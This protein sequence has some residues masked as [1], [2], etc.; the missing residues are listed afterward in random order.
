[1][2]VFPLREIHTV[3]LRLQRHLSQ[4]LSRLTAANSFG[5][6]G[7][8]AGRR[9]IQRD[10]RCRDWGV[11]VSGAGCTAGPCRTPVCPRRATAPGP[12]LRS[13]PVIRA[14]PQERL[15]AGHVRGGERPEW[16]AAPAQRGPLGCRRGARRPPGVRA[17]APP[18]RR[19]RGTGA[20]RDHL[21]QEGQPFGRGTAAVRGLDR[22]GDERPG[23]RLPDLCLAA[24]SGARG[25]GAVSPGV[26][27]PGPGAL[28]A[29][30]GTRRRRLRHHVTDGSPHDRTSHR[31]W[32]TDSVGRRGRGLRRGPNVAILAGEP[33]PGL[34][35]GYRALRPDPDRRRPVPGYPGDRRDTARL[36]VG[37]MPVRQR[38]SATPRL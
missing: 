28:P 1:M 37:T 8:L 29:G 3:T 14:G 5:A 16:H 30:G 21:P 38:V 32:N 27:D 2:A 10:V 7:A 12:Y 36:R 15:D 26:L 9:L 6:F 11:V 34:C 20:A 13:W 23:R 22:P 35:A 19:G 33:R 25:P 24:R 31:R 4:R 17:G 18:R